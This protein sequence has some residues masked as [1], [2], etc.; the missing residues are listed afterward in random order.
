M[1]IIYIYI[2][3]YEATGCWLTYGM[4]VYNIYI[5]I[6]EYEA[7]GCWLT[8]GTYVE[9][10]TGL[11]PDWVLDFPPK[12]IARKLF[13]HATQPA[14]QHARLDATARRMHAKTPRRAL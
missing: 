14:K 8:Y 12:V 2:A 13:R 4:N 10:P 5:Y 7:T 6:A 9:Y 11:S 1:Y 3:E